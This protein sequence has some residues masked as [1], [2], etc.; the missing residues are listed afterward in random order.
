MSRRIFGIWKND[1]ECVYDCISGFFSLWLC[2]AILGFEMSVLIG[3]LFIFMYLKHIRDDISANRT[4]TYQ[5]REEI[6]KSK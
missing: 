2:N 5:E 6:L 4:L 1:I 3:I